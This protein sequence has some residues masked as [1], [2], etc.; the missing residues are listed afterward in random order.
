MISVHE[1]A[2]EGNMKDKMQAI[3]FRGEGKFE[4][5]E[6]APVPKIEKGNEMFVRVDACS[7]CGTDVNILAVPPRVNAAK[8]IILG[9]EMTGTILEIGKDVHGYKPGDRI[10]IDNNLTCGYC[11]ECQ[12][13]HYNTCRNMDSM[14][15]MRDGIFAEYCVVPESAAT[16]IPADMPVDLAVFSEPVNCVMGG[17]QK[18][19]DMMPG[20]TVVVL[21][22]GPIGLYYTKLCQ[23]KGAGK[24]IVSEVSE[25]RAG[26]AKDMGASVVIDPSK[27]AMVQRVLDETNGYG[28]EIVIDTVGCLLGD[29]IKAV[30]PSGTIL[31]FGLNASKTETICQA[32]IVMKNVAVRGSYIGHFTFEPTVKLL[33]SG[34]VD[35]RNMITHRLALSDFGKGI[36]AMRS[37]KGLEVVLYP[38]KTPA[39]VEEMKH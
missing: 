24:I 2:M 30:R 4:Y 22:A 6:N 3:Y 33:S 14:G 32:D 17:I 8:D 39:E 5:T 28:A 35:F 11:E 31:L 34:I 21:G 19:G 16:K 27:E 13:G 9:H 12:T 26:Y 37:G 38:G 36:D 1:N 29:A 7:I 23:L 15:V 10:V 18:L 20:E 25:F